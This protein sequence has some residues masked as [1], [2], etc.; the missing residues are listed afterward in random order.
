MIRRLLGMSLA[1]VACAVLAEPAST[2]ED[3]LE[4]DLRDLRVGMRVAELPAEGMSIWPVAATVASR[5]W[6]S[7]VGLNSPAAGRMPRGLME[8]TFAYAESPSPSS[9][10]AGRAPKSPAIR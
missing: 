6:R 8:V 3:P 5:V 2:A 10:T 7:R 9:A 4:G 1:T